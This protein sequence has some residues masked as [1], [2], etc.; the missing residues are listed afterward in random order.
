LFGYNDKLAILNCVPVW[1]FKILALV[2]PVFNN[3]ILLYLFVSVLRLIIT[4]AF[5]VLVR[6][7]ANNATI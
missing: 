7:A 1:L 3:F 2:A 6:Y 5:Y 4:R